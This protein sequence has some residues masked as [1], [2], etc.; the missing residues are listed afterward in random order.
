MRIKQKL[1]LNIA[2]SFITAFIIAVILILTLSIVNRARE[3]RELVGEL[4][5]GSFE[6]ATLRSDFLR[7]GS[8]RARTQWFAK[9]EQ[10]D[11]LLKSAS[12]MF[13][14]ERDQ[15][16]I[17]EMT[18]DHEAAVT[19]FSR[20]VENRENALSGGISPELSRE[21]ENR[22][23]TQLNMRLYDRILLTNRLRESAGAHLISALRLAGWG[24]FIVIAAVAMAAAINTF[25]IGRIIINRIR[26]LEDGAS[27]L[28]QGNL[29]HRIDIK[30]DDE[31]VDL[32]RAFNAMTEKLRAYYHELQDEIKERRLA[33]KDLRRSGE[34]FRALVEAT[35]DVLYRMSPDWSEMF[36]LQSH[37][38]LA[39][40]EAPARDWLQAYIHPDDQPDVISFINKAIRTKGI[41]EL[42]HRV[43][44]ADGSLGWTFSRA[45]PVQDANG[46][47]IEWFG[48]AS[49]IT[50]RKRAEEA[51]RDALAR[52]EDGRSK[53][54]ENAVRIRASL[55]EKE[56]L[57]QEIHHRVKN[58]MQVI[59]S[60][61]ALQADEVRDASMHAIFEDLT[62]RVRSMAMIHEMLY[63][64]ADL[65]RVDFA[66]YARNLL[67]YLWRAHGTASSGIRLT[68]DLEPVSLS[69]IPAVPCGLILNE[70]VS[71][72][73]KHAFSGRTEGEIAVILRGDPDN[74]VHLRVRDDGKG[75]PKGFDWKQSHSL[76][77]RL[78]QLLSRQLRAEVE[79]TSNAGT[80]FTI[81]F[82]ERNI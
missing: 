53:L 25:T 26:L 48:A 45:V 29:E 61:I 33:E 80:E 54:R 78:V 39:D 52:A 14:D 6:R 71:N 65:A 67:D 3:K 79:V 11:R 38:F 27:I 60:L 13:N 76:G 64:S 74:G 62:H 10:I 20:I 18:E 56:N 15:K 40:T 8:K 41:F 51:L 58:N 77:L 46:E 32:S 2:F 22:L 21:I 16:T 63:Q 70:L 4:L 17:A 9:A 31:F 49:D 66:E 44:R 24:I 35:S 19:L 82:K 28:G 36:Q 57:L 81:T 42:E 72:A 37:E 43:L 1:R 23:V 7:T 50:E 47:I 59:S 5:S 68:L 34:R 30:G 73:I 69:I 55:K 75:L 12:D